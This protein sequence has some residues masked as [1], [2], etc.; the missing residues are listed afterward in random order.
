MP[1]AKLSPPQIALI[2]HAAGLELETLGYRS[3]A[4]AIGAVGL[5]LARLRDRLPWALEVITGS[6]VRKRGPEHLEKAPRSPPPVH[7]GDLRPGRDDRGGLPRQ[8]LVFDPDARLFLH[9]LDPD[10]HAELL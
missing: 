7:L 1:R 3:E 2:E 9:R 5:W 4:P 10:R 6:A 8:S